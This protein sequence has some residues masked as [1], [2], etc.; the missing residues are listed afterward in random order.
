MVKSLIKLYKDNRVLVLL[1]LA[2]L[3]L[4]ILAF[5]VAGVVALFNQPLGLSI[6]IV[7]LAAIVICVMNLVAWALVKLV[8]DQ[9][10]E[11][12]KPK[13]DTK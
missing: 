13:K 10:V 4:S 7:P 8:M 11:A 2:Y 5:F 6:L 3:V 12:N 9:I 1:D